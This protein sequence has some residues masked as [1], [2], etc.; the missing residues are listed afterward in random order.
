M[1]YSDAKKEELLLDTRYMDI[2]NLPSNFQPYRNP[3]RGPVFSKLLIRPMS[4]GELMLVSKAASMRDPSLV[5]RAVDLCI[6]EPV[7]YL[8]QGD[9]YYVLAWLR[10]N[11]SPK[12]P[13]IITWEC[14][15][16]FYQNRVT[17]DLIPNDATFRHLTAEEIESKEWDIVPCNT[18]NTETVYTTTLDIIQLPEE[19]NELVLPAQFDFPRVRDIDDVAEAM[20][21]DELQFIVPGAQWIYVPPSDEG[22]HATLADRIALLESEPNVDLF[23]EALQMEAQFVHG[24]AEHCYIQCRV[25]KARHP[26]KLNLAP[27]AFFQ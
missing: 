10:L 27:A 21:N 26:Y 22:K 14:N 25:C 17:G 5:R 4:I 2:G 7:D 15:S 8:S 19:P 1:L 11:S 9:Y 6:S 18:T 12:H 13:Y 16:S 20:K 23:T 24:I 3:E